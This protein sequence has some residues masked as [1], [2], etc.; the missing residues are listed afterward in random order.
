MKRGL[1]PN[2]SFSIFNSF[3]EWVLAP[4]SENIP[5]DMQSHRDAAL[6]PLHGEE[7]MCYHGS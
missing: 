4:I 7:C 1:P 6:L 2:A 3:D 5:T